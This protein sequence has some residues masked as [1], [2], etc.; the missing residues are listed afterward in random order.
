M[1]T[2]LEEIEELLGFGGVE[3]D[4]LHLSGTRN[5]TI[6]VKYDVVIA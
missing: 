3:M 5:V 1:I 2:H 4:F 6:D